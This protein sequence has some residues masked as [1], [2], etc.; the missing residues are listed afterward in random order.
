MLLSG[1][2]AMPEN[3][4]LDQLRSQY[5]NVS[6]YLVAIEAGAR[7]LSGFWQ[8]WIA[9]RLTFEGLAAIAAAGTLVFPLWAYWNERKISRSNRTAMVPW[10]GAPA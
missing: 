9:L 4:D 1:I 5:P 8:N 6:S 3:S 7:R 2:A 10:S